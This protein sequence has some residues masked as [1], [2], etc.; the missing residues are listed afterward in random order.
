MA[1]H[2]IA[3]GHY[4]VLAYGLVAGGSS[5]YKAL[6]H[7]R[8][9]IEVRVVAG[10]IVSSA[11]VSYANAY[12][13]ESVAAA[14]KHYGYDVFKECSDEATKQWKEN[15]KAELQHVSQSE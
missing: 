12:N 4:R 11:L 8:Y 1:Q 2:D 3:R 14:K 13:R 10:C 9:G 15:H 6:L 5:E 7:N